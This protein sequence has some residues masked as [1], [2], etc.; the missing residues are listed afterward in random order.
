MPRWTPGDTL[1]LATHN[2]GKVREIEDLLRPFAVPVVAAGTLG[3][4]EP[5]ETGLTFIANA[6]LKARAAAEG[7]GKP[8]LADD[9][10]LSVTGL[11]G[12][13][14]I[15][16]A[17]WAGPGKDFSV[18]MARVQAELAENADRSAAFHC[19]LS[20]AW[21]DGQIVTFEG[22]IEGTLTFPARG[23]N[24][25][26]YDPIFIPEGYSQT[27]GEMDA[28]AKHAMSHRALAFEQLVKA[29]FA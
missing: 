27:F 6:E 18:A 15:Y 28:A 21:P 3:L 11:G 17:R 10:G 13:P 16:S 14:G 8:A 23:P 1:V 26:G 22:I 24:G 12:A 20:L 7:S 25:F 29:V 4:P 9:S 2:P 5:E 19:A